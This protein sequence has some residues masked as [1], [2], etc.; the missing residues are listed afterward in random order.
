MTASAIRLA[1]SEDLRSITSQTLDLI[2]R[3]PFLYIATAESDIMRTWGVAGDNSVADTERLYPGRSLHPITQGRPPRAAI[4]STTGRSRRLLSCRPTLG[5]RA[6]SA[7]SGNDGRLDGARFW[8]Q[9]TSTARGSQAS[10]A[11]LGQ[12][13]PATGCDWGHPVCDLPDMAAFGLAC[14]GGRWPV[15]SW[16]GTLGAGCPP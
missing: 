5:C 12:L 16:V 8:Y 15:P 11:E 6:E 10:A 9:G 4:C 14:L 1:T 3:L 7:D 13:A 2:K